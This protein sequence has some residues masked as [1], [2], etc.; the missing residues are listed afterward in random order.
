MKATSLGRAAQH[1]RTRWFTPVPRA[2]REGALLV[3]V[4][5]GTLLVLLS[6]YNR[7]A[8]YTY[9]FGVADDVA[10][11][12][13]PER[14]ERFSYAYIRDSFT[15]ESIVT[16]RGVFR[17]VMRMGGP[18]ADQPV[19]VRLSLGAQPLLTLDGLR[20]I[21]TFHILMPSDASGT[22]PITLDSTFIQPAGETR[23][24]GALLDTME[25]RSLGRLH[26]PSSL[27]WAVP[28]ALVLVWLISTQWT[29]RAVVR[30][31]AAGVAGLVLGVLYGVVQAQRLIA[32]HWYLNTLIVA[33]V[34]TV[35]THTLLVPQRRA[36][37]RAARWLTVPLVIVVAT[38]LG[39]LLVAYIADPLIS[40]GGNNS[41]PRVN[42]LVEVLT[43][44]WD[45][46]FYYDIVT[47][48]Y[49]YNRETLSSV[50]YFPLLPLLIR[51]L[52]PVFGSAAAAGI[53]VVHCA[54]LGA[55][56]FFYRLVDME[57][58]AD[59]A[60][61]AVWYLLIFPM[62]FFGSFVYSESL[63]LCTAIGALWCARRGYWGIAA[64]L[65]IAAALSRFVGIVVAPML[66]LEWWMARR[67]PGAR[68]PVR[69][70][71]AACAVPLGT[72]AYMLYLQWTFGDPL[73]FVH[74]SASWG[75]SPGSPFAAI[76]ADFQR[77]GEGWIAA[78]LSGNV[79]HNALIDLLAVAV[80]AA[81]GCVLLA[82]HRWSEA[83]FVLLALMI[84]FNSGLLASQRRYVWVLFPAFI[85]L[86]RWGQHR[87][88]DRFITALFL[89]GLGLFTAM[90]A[91]HYWVA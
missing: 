40:D 28:L 83:A 19:M 8:H 35:A 82:Q 44:R 47:N 13:P 39:I 9:D 70:A 4:I 43:A 26:P 54:L 81:L 20:D 37:L 52:A 63:L 32:P 85:L 75:R 89:T 90:I 72:L 42:L 25:V 14:N 65:G 24:L 36:W 48:G 58:G 50:A 46:A 55:A 69:A 31:G 49:F 2:V 1:T 73:A 16:G 62:S 77:P 11:L 88:V 51:I 68:P 18:A 74:A 30:V 34:V 59:I 67:R 22:L 84:T 15:L 6:L 61:R 21:R 79:P 91:N 71:L 60:E 53:I 12:Y 23:T 56:I 10:G 86:A 33:G 41:P 45:S 27:Y 87:W 5:A 66:L 64:C 38:R 3:A 29:S 17:A 57:W 76:A 78:I 7:P 80:F